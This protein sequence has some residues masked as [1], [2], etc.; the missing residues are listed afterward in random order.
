MPVKLVTFMYWLCTKSASSCSFGSFQSGTVTEEAA[1]TPLVLR[2][3]KVKGFV[4]KQAYFTYQENCSVEEETV[5]P[6]LSETNVI[7]N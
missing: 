3:P 2:W 5:I 1:A 7:I 4:Y 6:E